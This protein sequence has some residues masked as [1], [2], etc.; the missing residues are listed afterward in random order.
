MLI[1]VAQTNPTVGD[2]HGNLEEARKAIQEA[3]QAGAELVVLPELALLGYPPGDLLHCPGFLDDADRALEQLLHASRGMGLVLGHVVRAGH[4]PSNMVDPSSAAFVAGQVLYNA[5]LLADDGAVVGQQIKH[6]LPSF[7]VFEEQR[8]FTPGHRVEVL[9]WRHLRVGLSVCEDLWYEGGVLGAQA[10][11]GVDLIVN[12]SASPYFQG[13]ASLR[14]TLAER[15]ARAAGATVLYTNMAGGQDELV[16]DGGSFAVR[17]DGAFLLAA[18]PFTSGVHTFD[19]A[20]PPV[21]PPT[22]MA[23]E[24]LREALVIG[25]RD[26]V[27]K[28]E[29]NGVWVAVSGGVDSALVAALAQEALGPNRVSTVFMPGPHTAPESREQ[30]IALTQAL[31]VHLHEIPIQPI[32]AQMEETLRGH[33][34]VE[35]L[36]AENLQA[37]VRGLLLMALCNAT[38]RVPLCP[39]NKAEI[40]VGYNTLYGDSVGA[41]API[42]DL[43]KRDVYALA[44][45]INEQNAREIIPSATLDRPPSAE[46]RPDQRDDQ[47]LPPYEQLDPLLW[48]LLVD[49]RPA[50]ELS[51]AYGE[52]MV[53]DVLVRLQ[54]SEYKRRQLP[55]VIKVT[56]KAFGTGRRMPITMKRRP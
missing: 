22:P 34:P 51:A 18:P 47:D 40:A 52:A 2:F 1:T 48:D 7:D 3:R 55:I 41:L 13:K 8:Y 6:H 15:W 11:A 17:P 42:G 39:A 24:G 12:V 54:R 19:L 5:V 4:G 44:Q 28:N 21:D 49:N 30:A 27:D 25:I 9:P 37:R 16:F 36:V 33:A 14:R 46:L 45:L 20:G 29:L 56:P 23:L 26:Y 38:D 53:H 35:G 31:D 43:L 50:H 10:D 32:L